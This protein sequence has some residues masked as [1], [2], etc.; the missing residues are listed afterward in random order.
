LLP[1]V[2]A[3]H[4]DRDHAIGCRAENVLARA[5]VGRQRSG[6]PDLLWDDVR[7]WFDPQ[8]NGVLPDVCVPDTTIADRQTVVDLVR[9]RGWAYEYSA[10]SEVRR[11]PDRV[12][13]MPG[14][15]PRAP[16]LL[17]RSFYSTAS[18]RTYAA[19]SSCSGKDSKFG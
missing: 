1:T 13:D 15:M 2:F 17:I 11:V 4:T 19:T 16:V 6:V 3:Y 8:E 10:D 7:D 14:R 18:L 9:S 12:E 5:G